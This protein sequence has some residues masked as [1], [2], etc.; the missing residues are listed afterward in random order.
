MKMVQIAFLLEIAI[1]NVANC[2]WGH[3]LKRSLGINHK[4]RVLYPG[5]RFLSSATWPSI[6]KTHYNGLINQSINQTI[7]GD[8][9]LP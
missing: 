4:R 5:H 1:S 7:F 3:E 6:L 8:W 2:L 9:C